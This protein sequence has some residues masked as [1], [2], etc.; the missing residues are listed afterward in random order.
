MTTSQLFAVS[1]EGVNSCYYCGAACDDTHR[2]TDYVKDTFTNRD[3]VAFPGSSFVCHGCA[4]SLGAGPDSMQMID[5]T[6]KVRENA[7][8]MQ[9]RM[10]SWVLTSGVKLAA[11]KAHIS[12][13]RQVVLDPP[14]PPFAII[15]TDSGQKQ[16]I[17]RAPIAL[18]QDH[19]P[20]LLEDERIEVDIA[21]LR[22]LL[23]MATKVVAATGKP[24]LQG[25]I[26]FGNINAYFEHFGDTDGIERWLEVRDR[27]LSRLAAWLCAAREE[28][29]GEYPGVECGSVPAAIG[30]TGGPGPG[31]AAGRSRGSERDGG[32]VLLDLG[33][34]IR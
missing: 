32:Q 7:R 19:Y 20:L 6:T 26:S 34:S 29:R 23:V 25:N 28:A 1:F 33:V 5:G 13:L 15:L 11:T 4:E 22:E 14:E 27:P 30:R 2:S 10:Y 18:S 8:G 9:P 16:L 31:D 21:S 12:L 24:A 3:I 17:F